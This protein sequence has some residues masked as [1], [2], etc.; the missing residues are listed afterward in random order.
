MT[1]SS[2]LIIVIMMASV[3]NS[4]AKNDP[5]FPP[6]KPNCKVLSVD[7]SRMALGGVSINYTN[8]GC[9]NDWDAGHTYV[10]ATI[11][12]GPFCVTKG[13]EVKIG[14]QGTGTDYLV[15][16]VG[17]EYGTAVTCSGLVGST[18]ACTK[19]TIPDPAP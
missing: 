5:C 19:A 15:F 7:L 18:G 14:P 10:D 1:R 2:L 13:T 9:G 17:N 6:A 8:I 11:P 12:H 3:S 16:T 4:Y